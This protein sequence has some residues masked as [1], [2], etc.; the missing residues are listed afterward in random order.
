MSRHTFPL[1]HCLLIAAATSG[2]ASDG[3]GRCAT[4]CELVITY[5]D[6][7]L[8][9]LLEE[10]PK[11]RRTFVY[12][13]CNLPIEKS[14]SARL[15]SQLEVIPSPNVGGN[16]YASLQ[17]IVRRYDNLALLTVFCEAGLHRLCRMDMVARPSATPP[18]TALPYVPLSDFAPPANLDCLQARDPLDACRIPGIHE[19]YV[20][21]DRA[22]R[23]GGWAAPR[24]LAMKASSRDRAQRA[25]GRR[26]SDVDFVPSGFN[27]LSAWLSHTVGP[28]LAHHLLSGGQRLVLGGFFAAE[29]A[30]L[31]RYP[32]S[33]YL[34]MARQQQHPNA[35]VDYFIERTRGLLLTTPT[36]LPSRSLLV[37]QA[38][39]QQAMVQM[40]EV[41]CPPSHATFDRKGSH[42]SATTSVTMAYVLATSP[43]ARPQDRRQGPIANRDVLRVHLAALTE[44]RTTML[45]RLMIMVPTDA[46]KTLVPGYLD[47]SSELERLPFHATIEHVRDN[48]LGSYGMFFEAY[49]RIRKVEHYDYFIFS[50]DDY[51]PFRAHYDAILMSM[52]VSTFGAT[53]YGLLA[54]ILQGRPLEPDNLFP[55]HPESSHIMSAN[56]LA[57]LFDITYNVRHWKHDMMLRG[58][59][60]AFGV[61]EAKGMRNHGKPVD[62][63]YF[64]K[65]QMCIGALMR[66]AAIPMRDWT[67][68]FRTPYWNHDRLVDWSGAAQGFTVPLERVLF[69]PIQWLYVRDVQVCCNRMNCIDPDLELRLHEEK[70]LSCNVTRHETFMSMIIQQAMPG[71]FSAASDHNCCPKQNQ[72]PS[73]AAEWSVADSADEVREARASVAARHSGYNDVKQLCTLSATKLHRRLSVKHQAP[74][75]LSL[76]AIAKA[77]HGCTT[78]KPLLIQGRLIQGSD[79]LDDSLH[80]AWQDS[81][82]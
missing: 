26:G 45:K 9:W 54:G 28:P 38:M 31:R 53:G 50:E 76:D 46:T 10:V 55:M 47:V 71:F 72:P 58:L 33:V 30:N 64:D 68:A 25:N 19:R 16:T 37:E 82:E 23:V 80:V 13:K 22:Q 78:C 62:M 66:D 18:I 20:F 43:F 52:Y 61:S 2:L 48:T 34:G 49:R 63:N 74:V 67:N 32:R 56:S 14:I 11:Y 27:N 29:A 39:V 57:H 24:E 35:E 51:I 42:P 7:P 5:C 1:L 6:E 36:N 44:L 73:E 21:A 59:T 12:S 75:A 79:A 60:L 3:P 40:P 8:T 17:H 70:L 15:G 81:S 41:A 69:A 65:V 77:E 4:R